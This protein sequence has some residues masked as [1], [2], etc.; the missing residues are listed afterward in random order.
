MRKERYIRTK[1][2]G[3]NRYYIVT[4][5]YT[6]VD[7]SKASY[8]KSFNAADYSSDRETFAAACAHR[9]VMRAKL[10]N[11]GLPSNEHL[12]VDQ[13]MQH[14]TDVFSQANGTIEL[15]QY[16]YTKYLQPVVGRKNIDSVTVYDIQCTINSAVDNLSDR[17]MLKLMC[18]W[19][20]IFTVAMSLNAITVVPNFSIIQVPRSKK[21]PSHHEPIVKDT[22]LHLIVNE[23][24]N[25]KN[26]DSR[27]HNLRVIS[28][29]L[30]VM[31]YTGMR[32]AECFALK[33]DN[34]KPDYIEI[35][36]S[37]GLAKGHKPE[38]RRTKTPQS[39]RKIPLTPQCKKELDEAI[40]LS[41]S[42]FVFANFNG[43]LMDVSKAGTH[44][45]EISK[46][47]GLDFRMYDLRHQFSTDLIIGGVDPRTV[48]ELMG[49][50]EPIMTVNYARSDDIK[51]VDAIA[52]IGKIRENNLKITSK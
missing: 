22:D 29:A 51:K 26:C 4:F 9:D 30:M 19:R 7:G 17:S 43:K 41:R 28:Y 1:T 39:A 49:H 11:A 14:Y 38:I 21:L 8:S 47:L 37:M 45:N 23:M 6:A 13:V 3:H 10:A 40:A 5:E 25:S 18:L 46:R 2:Y 27:Q 33:K 35:T 12:T 24:R 16:K 31:R 44:V 34:I 15:Y 50:V 48:M 52:E 20:K 32:P 42:E 36:H